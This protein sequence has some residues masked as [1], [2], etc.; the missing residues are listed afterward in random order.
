MR[1]GAAVGELFHVELSAD[2]RH[3]RVYHGAS[4]LAGGEIEHVFDVLQGAVEALV[5][6][7]LQR[8][9][10]AERESARDPV[11]ELARQQAAGELREGREG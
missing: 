8:S 10:R 9:A 2:G 6:A 1:Q 4:I 7:A 5:I 3:A 11:A